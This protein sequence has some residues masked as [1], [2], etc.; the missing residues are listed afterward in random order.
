MWRDQIHF[1]RGSRL[2]GHLTGTTPPPVEEINGKDSTKKEIK[3]PNPE[4]DEWYAQDQQVL[5]FVFVSL[6][7]EIMSQVYTKETMTQLWSAIEVMYSSRTRARAV[8]MRVTLATAQKGNQSIAKYVGKMRSLGDEMAAAGRRLEEEELVE[9][10]FT[11]LDFDFNPIVSVLLAQKATITVDEVYSQLL[12]FETRTELLAG[13][14][15]G[16]S[17]NMANRGGRGGNGGRGRGFNRSHGSPPGRGRGRGASNN[18][19]GNGGNN[20]SRQGGRGRVNT[21]RGNNN[22]RPLCQVCL[23]IG[24]TADCCWHHYDEDYVPEER[25]VAAAASTSYNIDPNW[26]TGT[27]ATVDGEFPST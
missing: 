27:G 25:H 4:F 8:N 18:N 9:Y 14:N 17:A 6:S 24:H 5:C 11:G 1:A 16:S 23:K 15:S 22:S 20:S 3:V 2:V 10:I 19:N 13:G 7:R 12:A 26:Y 21:G